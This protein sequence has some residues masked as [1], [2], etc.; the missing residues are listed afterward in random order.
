MN[1]VFQCKKPGCDGTAV[2]HSQDCDGPERH[3][4]NT[5]GAIYPYGDSKI[6]LS[7]LRKTAIISRLEG[8][9]E[10]IEPCDD[11]TKEGIQMIQEVIDVIKSL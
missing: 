3:E 4:C 8:A 2:Y 7:K 1:M 6:T 10:R 5:C 9:L 11:I